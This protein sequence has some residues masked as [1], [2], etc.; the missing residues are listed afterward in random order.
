MWAL[1][2]ALGPFGGPFE[3]NSVYTVGP[4]VPSYSTRKFY[5]TSYL[6]SISFYNIKTSSIFLKRR[7]IDILKG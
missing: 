6:V 3:N 4:F 5:F 7:L 1:M 2:W